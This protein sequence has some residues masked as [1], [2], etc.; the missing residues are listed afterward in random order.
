MRYVRTYP[1]EL[2]VLARTLSGIETPVL[3]IAGRRDRAVPLANAEFLDER[4]PNSRLVVLD[5]GHFAWEEAAGEYASLVADWVADGY[6]A[7]AEVRADRDRDRIT[8]RRR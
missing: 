3:I 4:L 6:R 7:A 5:A 8:N 2:P 1:D